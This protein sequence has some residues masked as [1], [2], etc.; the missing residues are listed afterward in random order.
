[1]VEIHPSAIVEEGFQAGDGV[2]VG[3]YCVVGRDVVL[4]ENVELRSHVIV[5]GR[6]SIGAGTVV[7]PFASIG[8]APQDIGYRGEPTEV[9]IGQKCII[10]EHVTIHRGT[11]R[12]RGRTTVGD[13][14]F[15]MVGAHV[16]HDCHLG[17][18]VTMVNLATIGGHV[19]V[20]DYAIL[21]GLS[22]VQQRVRI[23]ASA[24]VGGHSGI[25]GDLIPFGIGV[26]RGARLGGLN[27]VG[28]K[29]RGFDRPTIHALRAAYRTLFLEAN[30]SLSGRVEQVAEE[31]ADIPAV[32]S[33]VEFIRAA[34]GNALCVPRDENGD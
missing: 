9:S 25:G 22:A 26:G 21:G 2:R 15:L 1:M 4:G 30:G 28:L 13:G 24:F 33:V 29:R 12:G 32:M 20:G 5:A 6:V 23:G 11:V 10:R 17:N 34:D 18:N 3:P 16:A 27:I 31:Y 19:E 8:E 7:F 14:C